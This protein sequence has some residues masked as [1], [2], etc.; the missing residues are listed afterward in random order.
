[1]N[2]QV[3]Y[4]SFS[5]YFLSSAFTF[6]DSSKL[7]SSNSVP[8]LSHFWH[9]TVREEHAQINFTVR[10][11][12][13]LHPFSSCSRPLLPPA[14]R[15]LWGYAPFAIFL[16][17]GSSAFQFH[18]SLSSFSYC[19]RKTFILP[20]MFFELEA[21]I[22]PSLHRQVLWNTNQEWIPPLLTLHPFLS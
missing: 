9:L 10:K 7:V 16:C 8:L 15:N 22:S 18:W 14:F 12:L 11:H 5:M 6:R 2:G 21:C 19:K 13:N 1:M 20:S 3:L 17:P 4:V